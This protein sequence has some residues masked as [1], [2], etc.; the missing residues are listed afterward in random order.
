MAFSGNGQGRDISLCPSAGLLT[1]TSQWTWCCL[2][3]AVDFSATAPTNTATGDMA[4]GII[5]SNQSAGSERVTVRIAGISK[6]R[7]VSTITAGDYV[8]CTNSY[9]NY[10]GYT[11]S[12][13][14]T[15]G[16]T[17]NATFTSIIVVGGVALEGGVTGQV[18]TIDINKTL[19]PV[20]PCQVKRT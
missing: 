15:A 19:L 17:T 11:E 7:C 5:Q 10:S 18:I 3:T 16:T 6:A 14:V 4:Y 1:S 2:N 13:I 12:I 9:T 20:G 8:K